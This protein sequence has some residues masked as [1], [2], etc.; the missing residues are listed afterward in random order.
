MEEDED[1]SIKWDQSLPYTTVSMM[2]V[3]LR[4]LV[5]SISAFHRRR[6]DGVLYADHGLTPKRIS[7]DFRLLHVRPSPISTY[8][9]R[10]HEECQKQPHRR[11]EGAGAAAGSAAEDKATAQRMVDLLQWTSLGQEDLSKDII[12]FDATLLE[13]PLT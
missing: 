7:V 12:A 9:C 5:P 1:A 8:V 4:Y 11:Y 10:R 3:I 6:S 2:S 13:K